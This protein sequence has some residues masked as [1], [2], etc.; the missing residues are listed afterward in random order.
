MEKGRD[1]EVGK[2]RGVVLKGHFDFCGVIRVGFRVIHGSIT[3][4]FIIDTG[5]LTFCEG[6]L[7]FLGL[8][9]R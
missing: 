7:V 1:G 9:F 2:M 8:G 4:G 6:D 3:T 5:C